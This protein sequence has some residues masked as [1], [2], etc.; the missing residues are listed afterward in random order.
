[1]RL[2]VTL[3]DKEH[4]LCARKCSAR[5]ARTKSKGHSGTSVPEPARTYSRAGLTLLV[6][7]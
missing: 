5:P 6:F 1:M 7:E 2:H 4:C 3:R